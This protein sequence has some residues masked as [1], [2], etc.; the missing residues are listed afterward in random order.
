MFGQ[1]FKHLAPLLANEAT[2]LLG[3]ERATSQRDTRI[4][5]GA[6]RW[7][8]RVAKIQANLAHEGAL[9]QARLEVKDLAFV[10]LRGQWM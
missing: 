10:V 6:R 9:R 8:C 3:R 7:L 1:D 4:P 5:V 2:R